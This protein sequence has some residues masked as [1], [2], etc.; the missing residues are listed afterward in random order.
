MNLE[1]TDIKLFFFLDAP[2]L[3]DGF[4]CSHML[5]THELPI[6]AVSNSLGCGENELR[7]TPNNFLLC[8]RELGHASHL[9]ASPFLNHSPG[10]IRY[11]LMEDP[12]ILCDLPGCA[13][14]LF[15]FC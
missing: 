5:M 15:Q 9:V 7:I 3:V 12:Y 4:S 8:N 11:F 13:L 14:N 10:I 1:G 2:V 6:P